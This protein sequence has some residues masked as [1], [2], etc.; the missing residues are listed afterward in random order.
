MNVRFPWPPV[1]AAHARKRLARAQ[2]CSGS[3][4]VY[5]NYPH[6]HVSIMFIRS[7]HFLQTV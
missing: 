6:T 3:Y 1:V 7:Y 4:W 2:H 5:K